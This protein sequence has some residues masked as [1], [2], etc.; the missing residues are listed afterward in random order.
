LI[1]RC[2]IDAAAE[3]Y[4]TGHGFPLCI[5]LIDYTTDCLLFNESIDVQ[6]KNRESC[7]G[8]QRFAVVTHEG[9]DLAG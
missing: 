5:A 1:E 4:V 6:K 7:F 3:T 2:R 8:P 9:Q